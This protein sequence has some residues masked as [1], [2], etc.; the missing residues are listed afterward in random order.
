MSRC[1]LISR[2]RRTQTIGSGD[3]DIGTTFIFLTTE[4]QLKHK[5]SIWHVAEVGKG[6]GCRVWGLVMDKVQIPERR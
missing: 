2:F 6:G 3:S 4:L 1:P 5:A